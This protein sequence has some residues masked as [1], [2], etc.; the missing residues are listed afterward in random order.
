MRKLFIATLLILAI[1][2]PRTVCIKSR[3]LSFL[4]TW[5]ERK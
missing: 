3:V 2:D 4:R 5:P 1:F